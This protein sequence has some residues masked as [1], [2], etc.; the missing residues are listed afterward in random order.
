MDYSKI[1]IRFPNIRICLSEGGVGW[2]AG[3]LDRLDHVGRYQHM[4]GTWEGVEPS[5]REVLQRNFW[6]CAIEDPAALE[7]RHRIGIDHICLESDYPHQDGT[8]PDTQEIVWSQIGGFPRDEIER[9]AWRNASELF[10]HP[11]PEAL[12]RDPYAD[13]QAER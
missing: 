13:S 12:Q 6:F 4:Y 8:W 11:V 9:L 7:Q 2:V 3:L 1:P 5:P 10:H